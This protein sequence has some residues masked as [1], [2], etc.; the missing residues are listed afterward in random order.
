[1]DKVDTTVRLTELRALM[2]ERNI[3]VYSKDTLQLEWLYPALLGTIA[4]HGN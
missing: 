4:K 2:K 1:M 3:H